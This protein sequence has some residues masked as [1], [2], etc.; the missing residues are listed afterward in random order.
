MKNFRIG[1]CDRD[2]SYAASL[3]NALNA[4]KKQQFS[5]VAFS[6]MRAVDEYLKVDTLQLLLTDDWRECEKVAAEGNSN[7]QGQE[8][9]SYH[10]VNA[11]LLTE[12][13][14]CS[15]QGAE[16]AKYQRVDRLVKILVQK[17]LLQTRFKLTKTELVAVYSPLGRGGVTRFAKAI[18]LSDNAGLYVG[19]ENF[20]DTE[21]NNDL[22][23]LV[24]T[25]SPDLQEAL[26]SAIHSEE[27]V[28]SLYGAS[29]FLD[30]RDVTRADMKYLL[31]QLLQTRRFSKI[32]FD[33]GS[34]AIED[35]SILSCFDHIYI[36]K[37]SDEGANAKLLKFDQL[38]ARMGQKNLTLKMREVILPDVPFDHP[39][40]IRSVW[41]AEKNDAW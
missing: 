39:D 37:L 38:L 11:L 34:A 18:A 31:T 6:S 25:K 10:G 2:V 17:S 30:A 21:H 8:T 40:M 19:M 29:T 12:D 15:A 1:I 9:W 22:F 36:P 16:I 23:F 14:V 35:L 4:E 13:S 7:E 26:T 24:K 33:F 20:Q 32:V 41:E 27:G 5:C 28:F 3:V